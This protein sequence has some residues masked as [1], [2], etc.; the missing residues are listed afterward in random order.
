MSFPK[1]FSDFVSPVISYADVT[2]RLSSDKSSLKPRVAGLRLKPLVFINNQVLL[3]RS[4][5]HGLL[6]TTEAWGR[7]SRIFYCWKSTQFLCNFCT[8]LLLLSPPQQGN[9]TRSVKVTR[10]SADCWRI[11]ALECPTNLH[12]WSR[13]SHQVNLILKNCCWISLAFSPQKIGVQYLTMPHA[14]FRLKNPHLIFVV[15]LYSVR[16]RLCK[17]V[18]MMYKKNGQR[19]SSSLPWCLRG[20]E[21]ILEAFGAWILHFPA[22]VLS[23]HGSGG[24]PAPPPPQHPKKKMEAGIL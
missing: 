9:L 24:A 13:K 4:T 2:F 17:H 14:T 11:F 5:L 23:L 15:L 20:W 7:R 18:S 19:M 21:C 10:Q 1:E 8:S 12:E 16:Y 6:S 3:T 22:K